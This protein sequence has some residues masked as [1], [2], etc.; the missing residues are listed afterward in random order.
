MVLGAMKIGV[1][2]IYWPP[3]FGG[4]EKYVHS[5]VKDLI[6]NGVDAYGIT[7]TL[8][9]DT[10]DNGIDNIYRLGVETD[11]WDEM[12]CKTWFKEVITHV[13]ENNYT[14]IMINSPLTRVYYGYSEKLFGSLRNVCPN[15]KIGVV[16]HDLGIKTRLLLEQQYKIYND[17]EMSAK[18]VEGE[19]LKMFD[20]QSLYF[21]DKVAH[22]SFDSPLYFE[23]DF[24]IGNTKWS[25]RFID[26]LHKIP[27]FNLHPPLERLDKPIKTD[28]K[29]VNITMINPLFH[30]GRSYM[31]D[32]INDYNNK[33][34]FRVLLGSYGGDKE[35]FMRMIKDSWAVRE[36]R[37][38]IINY[39]EDIED[40]YDATDVFIYPSRYEGY[41][42]AAVEPMFRGVPVLVQDYPAIREA[43][44]DAAIIMPYEIDSREW[45]D[46]VE[47]LLLDV[48][49]YE[50]YRNRGIAHKE[51][52]CSRQDEEVKELIKFLEGMI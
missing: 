44:G 48:D 51:F 35:D 6:S 7:A 24:L 5:M 17:W 38:D 23:P 52:L 28:L 2:S 50:G 31:A 20:N 40:V 4:A 9:S 13:A 3:R 34:T 18:V 29:R 33:W 1:V 45:I 14:H 49:Y 27:K 19:Q 39:V 16:H 22:W 10:M 43:V 26:P 30:K 8:A 21:T 37:V 46:T 47:E 32:F 42:M 15:L 36:G 41:G 11:C 12:G 25:N